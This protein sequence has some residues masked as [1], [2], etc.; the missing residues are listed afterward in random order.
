MQTIYICTAYVSMV[1][2]EVETFQGVGYQDN[3]DLHNNVRTKMQQKEIDDLLMFL[4]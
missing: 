4:S 1:V 3:F 2:L